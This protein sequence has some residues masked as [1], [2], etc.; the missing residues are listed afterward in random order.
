MALEPR[1]KRLLHALGSILAMSGVAFVLYRFWQ[2]AGQIDWKS[3]GV[4]GWR[5]AAISLVVYGL[6]QVL[7]GA[8]WHEVMRHLRLPIGRLWSV[9]VY[10]LTQIAKYVP[11]NVFHFAGRQAIGMAWGLAGGTLLKSTAGEIALQCLAGVFF[12]FLVAPLVLPFPVWTGGAAF[13]PALA[14][15]AWL[16]QR[17]F[18]APIRRA[19][20]LDVV[21]LAVSG[22]VFWVL[23]SLCAGGG[24][25][26]GWPTVCG[27]FI[28]A[29]LAGL[30][31]PGA[32]AGAGIREMILLFL[33]GQAVPE[34][35]LLMALVLSR[36]VTIGGDV[37]FYLFALG[38]GPLVSRSEKTKADLHT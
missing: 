13:L 27:A 7:L 31:V 35:D 29:W 6:A 17:L 34:S 25:R 28:L 2:S 32:P 38:M 26:L 4:S 37:V 18:S 21:F 14:G 11:G 30:V 8:A 16:L 23:L 12:S 5:T 20:L 33:F 19:F 9:R 1:L 10:G 15:G 24:L 3:L 36:A 22:T